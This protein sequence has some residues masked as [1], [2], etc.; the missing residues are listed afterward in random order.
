MKKFSFTTAL[1]AAGLL[2]VSQVSYANAFAPNLDGQK[3]TT[4]NLV[5]PVKD[6]GGGHGGGGGGHGS[7]SS[8]GHANFT[9]GRGSSGGRGNFTAGRSMGRSTMGNNNTMGR[10]MMMG[11]GRTYARHF[12]HNGGFDGDSFPGWGYGYDSLYLEGGDTSCFWNCR[13]AG[14]GAGYCQVNSYNFCE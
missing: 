3:T 1:V 6:G 11:H 10:S 5:V 9:A 8:G 13:N 14:Y 12:R 4:S 7:F 2:A